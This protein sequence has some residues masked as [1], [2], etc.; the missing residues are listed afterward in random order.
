MVVVAILLVDDSMAYESR[1]VA[2]SG[3]IDACMQIAVVD[4]G[5]TTLVLNHH[6]GLVVEV[7]GSDFQVLQRDVVSLIECHHAVVFLMLVI[8]V[9]GSGVVIVIDFHITLTTFAL[10]RQCVHGSHTFNIW[11]AYFLVVFT[12]SDLQRHGSIHA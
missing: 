4:S 9:A 6:H 2:R 7:G 3:S 11:Y 8:A 12:C 5:M 1:S 10:Q